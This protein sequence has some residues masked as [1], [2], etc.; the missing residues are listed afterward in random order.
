MKVGCQAPSFAGLG[1]YGTLSGP[2]RPCLVMEVSDASAVGFELVQLPIGPGEQAH[3]VIRLL[4][5]C[6]AD[7]ESDARLRGLGLD[8]SK[9]LAGRPFGS[10]RKHTHELVAPIAEDHILT[11]KAYL[12]S[13]RQAAQ[14]LV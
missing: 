9:L 11:A 5:L 13:A 4:K 2:A 7:A 10:A 1:W 3:D 6:D 14:E 12:Q 8:F